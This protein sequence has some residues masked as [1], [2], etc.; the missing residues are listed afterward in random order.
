M[1]RVVAAEPEQPARSAVHQ[2]LLP[3]HRHH[4]LRQ[5]PMSDIDA[6]IPHHRDPLHVGRRQVQPPLFK[7]HSRRRIIAAVRGHSLLPPPE[8]SPRLC[9]VRVRHYAAVKCPALQDLL[10]PCPR[11]KGLKTCGV[12]SSEAL[13]K[14]SITGVR[15]PVT[16]DS[17]LMNSTRS[18][19]CRSTQ[20]ITKGV[21]CV[22][23]LLYVIT[24]PHPIDD[25]IAQ[26]IERHHLERLRLRIK[27]AVHRVRQQ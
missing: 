27:V 14:R 1:F 17:C 13:S 10:L 26:R 11:S 3:I 5:V 12:N 19:P 2:N 20:S 22:A 6:W 23:E 8:E 7:V 16:S 4:P 15:S 21:K 9:R 18:T 25:R 24:L